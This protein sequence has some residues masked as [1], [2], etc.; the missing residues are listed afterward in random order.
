MRA[1][2]AVSL[3]DAP[4]SLLLPLVTIEVALKLDGKY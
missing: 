3:A 2:G 4:L 1:N